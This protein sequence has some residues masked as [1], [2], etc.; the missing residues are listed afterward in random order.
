M[1]NLMSVDDNSFSEEVLNS[2]VPVLV[3]FGAVWCGPCQ[4]M[5]PVLEKLATEQE[6]KIKV[7]KVDIDDCPTL[8]AAHG[9]R[10]VPTLLLF[11]DG[12]KVHTKVGMT[13]L[14]DLNTIITT[15]TTETKE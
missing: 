15:H 5:L 9:I 3:E 4:R 11:K 2:K 10:S 8:A 14:N 6:S 1:S 13:S 12:A 7:V